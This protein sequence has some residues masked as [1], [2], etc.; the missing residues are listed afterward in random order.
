M[1][2]INV[3][4]DRPTT[5][6]GTRQLDTTLAVGSRFPDPEKPLRV[7]EVQGLYLPIE[8]RALGGVRVKLVDQRGFVTF[9]NQRDFEVIVGLGLPD[10]FCVWSGG[11]YVGPDHP[12]WFGLC[13]DDDDLVDDLFDREMFLRVQVEEAQG[14]VLNTSNEIARRVHLGGSNDCEE[15]FVLRWDGDPLTGIC[16]DRRFETVEGRWMRAERRRVRW[17]RS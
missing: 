5:V 15:L 4:R 1:T 2:L 6:P 11:T 8:G 16:P 7:W 13:C 12:D 10:G 17:E 9:C 3:Y 14:G